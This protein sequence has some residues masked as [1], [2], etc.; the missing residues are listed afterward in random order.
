MKRYILPVLLMLTVTACTTR[1]KTD[2]S[3]TTAAP[4]SS[5]AA[6]FKKVTAEPQFDQLKIN[7]RLTAETGSF[8]PPLDAT[9]YLEK[10]RKIWVNMVA[11]F[12]N[13]GRGLAT[14]A[15]IQGY[16]KWNKTYIESDFTYL[17]NLLNVNFIDFVS[18]QN[19]LLG[20][21]FIPV[22]ER[23]FQLIQ[24][25]AD[26]ILKSKKNLQ[27]NTNGKTSEYQAELHYDAQMDLVKVALQKVKAADQLEVTYS[28]WQ[29]FQQM[30]VPGTVKIVIKGNKDSK[31]TLENTK[32]DNSK[33][34]TPY[35]VPANYT[36][37][38]IK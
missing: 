8:V 20:K 37:T 31:I 12:L 26:Y 5:A 9:I 33:M 4:V 36:K 1:T 22:N 24:N 32:F 23:D 14:P 28:N 7:T 10:D 38:E 6:F 21:T 29:N 30:R 34:N 16:E 3:G 25:G 27:F 17:N 35:S 13:V 19:L 18:F 15:G 11:V 2:D